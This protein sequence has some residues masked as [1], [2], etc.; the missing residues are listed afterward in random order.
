MDNFLGRIFDSRAIKLNLDSKTK[1]TAFVEL[2]DGI[3]AINP[4]CNRTEMLAAICKREEKINTGIGGCVAIPHAYCRGIGRMTGAIGISQDGIDY[5]ALD[6]KPVN[7]IFL[8]GMSEQAD[9]NHLRILNIL[10]KLARSDAAALLKNAKNVQ[11]IQEIL[12]RV[13]IQ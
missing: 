5:G 12:S 13:P 10:F 11:D 2:I 7:I 6:N 1:E 9:E 4:E 8:I 3:A